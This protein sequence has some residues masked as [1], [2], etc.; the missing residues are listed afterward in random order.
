M[1]NRCTL[2]KVVRFMTRILFSLTMGLRDE[3]CLVT[4][5]SSVTE[6]N[7]WGKFYTVLSG[8]SQ[9]GLRGLTSSRCAL[10]GK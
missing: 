6:I 2:S 1:I 10:P 4:I 8:L 3:C 5:V 9:T 7:A